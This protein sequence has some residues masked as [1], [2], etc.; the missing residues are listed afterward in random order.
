M[1]FTLCVLFSLKLLPFLTNRT[2][3]IFHRKRKLYNRSFVQ[4]AADGKTV[5]SAELQL[6]PLINVDQ[7]DA[8][9]LAAFVRIDIGDS[10]LDRFLQLFQPLQARY[11]HR[12]R[13]PGS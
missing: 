8:V 4:D 1:D 10:H 7:R 11:L 6:N 9:A 12:R 2:F 13:I 3:F 5:F